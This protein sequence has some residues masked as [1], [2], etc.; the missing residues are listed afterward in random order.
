MPELAVDPLGDGVPAVGGTHPVDWLGALLGVAAVAGCALPGIGEVGVVSGVPGV[1]GALCV[2]PAA[3]VVIGVGGPIV[4]PDGGAADGIVAGAAGT[5]GEAAGLL[6][7]LAQQQ[8]L[9]MQ[10]RIAIRMD[11]QQSPKIKVLITAPELGRDPI[12]SI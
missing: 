1:G 6:C 4:E 12:T 3:L 9:T 7:A 5:G 10:H 8:Q 2:G 11:I